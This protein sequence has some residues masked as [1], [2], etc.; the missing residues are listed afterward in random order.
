MKRKKSLPL[1]ML[2]CLGIMM[3]LSL[4]NLHA[5]EK[6]SVNK[7]IDS[8]GFF[9]IFPPDGWRLQEYP[10]DPRGKVAFYGPEDVELRVLV[11]GIDYGFED[12]V[13]EMEAQQK[14]LGVKTN[15]KRTDL[16]GT[17]A[18]QRTFTYNGLKMYFVDLAVGN[19][20]HNLMYSAMPNMYE[21]YLEIAQ[22]SIS[23]YEPASVEVSTEDIG[24]HAIAK[25][26]RLSRI[27]YDQGNFELSLLFIEEGLGLEPD[28][29]ELLKLKEEI[30][31]LKDTSTASSTGVDTT[32]VIETTTNDTA[33]AIESD[34]NRSS[35]EDQ[36]PI[37]PVFFM[38]M[39]IIGALI[40]LNQK[41]IA[42]GT[43]APGIARITAPLIGFGLT[44]VGIARLFG[45]DSV[46][47]GVLTILLV[48]LVFFSSY[49]IPWL[50]K[51]YKEK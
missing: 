27:F 26:L 30:I 31:A 29:S 21:K 38:G 33:S 24:K 32:S 9:K 37:S 19:T 25:S 51:K 6:L 43:A 15:I 40:L 14:K 7:Y 34:V 42:Q 41:S 1:T 49:L 18:I 39:S 36:E 50:I 16:G 13:K 23:T 3:T 28:D 4:T 46:V 10:D 11:K 12:M 35:T 20:T 44:F 22:L 45:S 8:K 48:L 17:Q 5:K 47:L 2:V